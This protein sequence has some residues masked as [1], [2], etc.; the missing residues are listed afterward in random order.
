VRLVVDR[1]AVVV[2]VGGVVDVLVGGVVVVVV[3]VIGVVVVV[4]WVS[5]IGVSVVCG[6]VLWLVAW[7]LACG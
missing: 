6:L 3:R 1:V 4:F 5:V 7:L 2:L